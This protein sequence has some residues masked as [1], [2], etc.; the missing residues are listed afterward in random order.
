MVCRQTFAHS[1]YALIG[2]AAADGR[3]D[4]LP[5][6]DY[7]SSVLWRR[8][9]GVKVLDVPGGLAKGRAVRAYAFCAAAGG[10]AVVVL[11]TLDR[12]ASLHLETAGGGASEAEVYLLTSY[13]GVPTSRDV[14]LNGRVLRLA[15]AATGELPPLVPLRVAAGEPILLPPKSYGFVVLPSSGLSACSA[16]VTT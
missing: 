1:D 8:L 2:A 9:V 14:F 15:D 11:N 10:V 5:N 3:W 16:H 6:P 13:P 12:Q 7:W 4:A